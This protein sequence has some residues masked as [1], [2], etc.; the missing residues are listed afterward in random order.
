MADLIAIA[1]DDEHKAEEVRLAL[2]KLQ[3]S[4]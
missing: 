2:V 3:M 4:I 1:Y